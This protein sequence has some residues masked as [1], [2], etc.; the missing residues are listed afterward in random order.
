MRSA[1]LADDPLRSRATDEFR[2]Q[3]DA[4]V[5]QTLANDRGPDSLASLIARQWATPTSEPQ[6]GVATERPQP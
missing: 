6:S 1:S 5:A 3:F 2:S 4:T